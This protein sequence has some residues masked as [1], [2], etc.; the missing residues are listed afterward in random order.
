MRPGALRLLLVPLLLGTGGCLDP[1]TTPSAY[2]DHAYL[3]EDEAAWR[4][5][6]ARCAAQHE[7]PAEGAGCHGVLSLAGTILGDPMRLS[8]QL[9]WS[10]VV[11]AAPD[12]EEA[13]RLS[14]VE[15]VGVAPYFNLSLILGSVGGEVP[16]GARRLGIDEGAELLPDGL[17]DGVVS[18]ALRLAAGGQRE[19]LFARS[20]SGE[21]VVEVPGAAQ[22]VARFDG[23]FGAQ[24]DRVRGCLALHAHEV[25][26]EA[27]P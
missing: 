8:L 23:V 15:A 18:L 7:A 3:C 21:V 17:R 6:V 22:A 20:G 11:T 24:A 19:V 13:Q 5:E 27:A 1:F 10:D 25:R 26:M 4:A 12:G 2:E 14:R 9:R 16:S